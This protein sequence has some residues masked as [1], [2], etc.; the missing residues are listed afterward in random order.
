MAEA[1]QSSAQAQREGPAA[2]G[3]PRCTE[4]VGRAS[5]GG[6]GSESPGAV[7]LEPSV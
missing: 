1:S 6:E 3:V 4:R 7:P 2:L 5:G